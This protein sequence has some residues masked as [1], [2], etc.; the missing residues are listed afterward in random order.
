MITFTQFNY[1]L[2]LAEEK[3]FTKAAKKLF[4]TQQTL[5]NHILSIE[6][7]LDIKL[8]ERSTPLK[9]TYAGKIFKKY[10]L[11]FTLYKNDLY[12]EI[13]DIKCSQKG[14]FNFGIAY[15]RGSVILPWLL[16]ILKAEFPLIDFFITEGN[17][18]E[19]E[20]KLVNGKLDLIIEQLPFNNKNISSINICEDKL[21]MLVSD[22]FL[23]KRFG[24]EFENI[25]S[26]L[27]KDGKISCLS[28]CTFLLNKVGNSIRSRVEKILISEGIEPEC[29]IETENMETLLNLCINN[30]G[31]TF[32]P[33]L[34]LCSPNGVNIPSNIN[35]I[36][37][38][39][40][41]TSYTL[42]AAYK[43]DHYISVVSSRIV[44]LIRS[45]SLNYNFLNKK[46]YTL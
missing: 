43:K 27:L 8:F 34:F 41:E 30:Y 28:N 14:V 40:E 38:N 37:L 21:Y 44:D 4:I 25:K 45:F 29:R 35:I 6:K 33:R 12:S 23:M 31:I 42:G 18:A 2:T 20:D 19:L 16:P 3:N 7:E 46:T 17:H 10:A 36:P 22:E 32:Y 24:D 15:N 1:F 5:S 11:K 13:Q 39:Y 9:L 26:T